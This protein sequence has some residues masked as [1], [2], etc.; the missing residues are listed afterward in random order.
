[1]L[2]FSVNIDEFIS[3]F[4]LTKE[5][6]SSFTS[7]LLD[8][9]VDE[10]VSTWERIIN[11]SLHETREEYKKGIYV[12]H[13]QSN[14]AVVGLTSRQSRLSLMIENGTTPF[15]E[16]EGFSRSELKKAKKDGGWYLTIPF[17]H[18]VE[19]EIMSELVPT[20]TSTVLEFLKAS[21]NRQLTPTTLP[22]HRNVVQT[23]E[24]Q[25][26]SVTI[27]YTHKNPIYEGLHRRDISST[28]RERRG[29]YFTFRRV[30]DKSDLE[31]WYHPGFEKHNF[32]EQAL[33]EADFSSVIE[34]AREE[35]IEKKFSQ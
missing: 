11:S 7:F 3:E 2:N 31:S 28:K 9:V 30:S 26:P 23:S 34:I 32:M 14:I 21:P 8:R 10:Y 1:M 25:T 5:E 29:G 20:S 33:Q 16:K 18:S 24:I 19:S 12:D 6:V 15:D 13:I 4:T 35:F 27:S 17:R 22:E